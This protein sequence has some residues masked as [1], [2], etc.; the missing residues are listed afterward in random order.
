MAMF[1][2]KIFVLTIILLVMNVLYAF[3]TNSI[4]EIKEDYITI[5]GITVV[6]PPKEIGAPAFKKLK[7]INTEW[8]SFVPYG[9]TKKGGT[10]VRYNLEW[11]WWGEKLKGVE[12][13][14]IEAKKQGLKIMLKPQVFIGGGWVGGMDFTSEQDWKRWEDSYRSFII[15]YIS[16]AA[17]HNVEM[18]CIGTEFNIAVIK[19]EKYWKNLIKEARKIYKGKITYSANWDKYDKTNI[20]KELDYV[21][22]SSYFPLSDANNPTVGLLVKEWRPII[23]K[24][25]SFAELQGKKILFTEYGYMSVDG[26]AGKAWEIEKSKDKLNINHFAQSNAYDALWT[27]FSDQTFWAGGFLWKWFPDGMGHEGYPEK[28]YTPQNKPAEKII[29]KWFNQT[30]KI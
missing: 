18:F 24:L 16:I 21:G 10:D 30:R 17:K 1:R 19:R 6:A 22:I 13:C 27:A 29:Q 5:K 26:C 8:V 14:I 4:N 25:K 11:Q 7:D 12:S 20:W 15:D 3:V 2:S 23:K 28:D 9:F